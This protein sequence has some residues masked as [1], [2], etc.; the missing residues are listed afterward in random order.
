MGIYLVLLSGEI[1][2]TRVMVEYLKEDNRDKIGFR[3]RFYRKSGG[4]DV[5]GEG[6]REI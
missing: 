1:S 3:H 5:N 2:P 6:K 4:F